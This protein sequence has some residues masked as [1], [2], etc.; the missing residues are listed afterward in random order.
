MT[1]STPQETP[2]SIPPESEEQ[3]STK[4]GFLPSTVDELK[5]VVWPS[6]QQLFSESIAVILM[7]TL[8]AASIAAVS[9]FYG[10]GASQ[11]FR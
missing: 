3:P 8:S 1:S 6:R 5:L 10:W 2:N 9:R 4:K 7:V 11:I